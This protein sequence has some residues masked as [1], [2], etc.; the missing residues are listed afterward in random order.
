MRKA[1]L[2]PLHNFWW[3][4][5]DFT[6]KVDR[7]RLGCATG[8]LCCTDLNCCKVHVALGWREHMPHPTPEYN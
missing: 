1:K 3:H 5:Y 6:A 2:S 8:R 7:G 4:I